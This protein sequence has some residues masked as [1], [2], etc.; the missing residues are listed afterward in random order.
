[1]ANADTPE[2]ASRAIRFG[3]MGIGLCRTERMFNAPER[4]PI[5]LDMIVAED[6][7]Q[8]AA[9]LARLLPMQR[10]D[11]RGIFEAMSPRPVTIRL[12]DPPI[13]E[14]LPSKEK[15]EEEILHLHQL[16][17]ALRGMDVLT[18]TMR[19][20]EAD[21]PGE[22]VAF[23]GDAKE[24][25]D[26]RRVDR[27]IAR[28]EA[29]LRGAQ[30]LRETN[31]MLGHR[32]VRL[33][34]TYP[35]IYQMQSQSRPRGRR[36]MPQGGGRGP[37]PDHGSAG[38]HVPGA[39][40]GERY[41]EEAEAAVKA[42]YGVEIDF[43]FGTMIEVVR[44]CLR[45]ESLAEVADFF[46][47]GTNDLTQATFSFSREDAETKFLPLYNERGILQDNPF[48][49]LDRMGLGRLMAVT[50][51]WARSKQAGFRGRDL[52]RARR[53]SRLDP[54]LPRDRPGLRFLLAASHPGRST[55][56]GARQRSVGDQIDLVV[57]ADPLVHVDGD[58]APGGS[59][60]DGAVLDL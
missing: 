31:P 41:V 45:A 16:R 30:A 4:L 9:A 40:A 3:A 51:Q 48:E 38:L 21:E 54:L 11:F 14:F 59:A 46:S 60:L 43:A 33:G 47:F 42:D 23:A 1:M 49:V 7:E 5:V 12:L 6:D 52:R 15:L 25:T 19:V 44:A 8:R 35:E 10:A 20:L 32:G 37:S 27:V 2:D 56:G 36:G 53:P 13:H 57:R 22:A 39:G 29:L 58:L 50:V 26:V 24:L 18:S 34:L 28:K 55:G 17:D